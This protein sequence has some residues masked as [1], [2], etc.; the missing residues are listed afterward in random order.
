MKFSLFI[1]CNNN[2][3]LNKKLKSNELSRNHN[4]YNFLRKVNSTLNASI[5]YR[6]LNEENNIV[7]KTPICLIELFIFI[8]NKKKNKCPQ[9][10]HNRVG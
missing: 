8:D 2:K 10:L 3:P 1:Y 4:W 5:R 7:T 6:H 9:N